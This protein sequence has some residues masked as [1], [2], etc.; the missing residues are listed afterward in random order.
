MLISGLNI[1]SC[2]TTLQITSWVSLKSP[3]NMHHSHSAGDLS[4]YDVS[5]GDLR[6]VAFKIMSVEVLNI[7]TAITQ[8]NYV[9]S[10]F[11]CALH[12]S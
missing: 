11:L 7:Q 6:I 8:N 4:A 5:I 3:K 12:S 9:T 1:E 2:T 10:C